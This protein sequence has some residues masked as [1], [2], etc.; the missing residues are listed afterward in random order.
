M[1]EALYSISPKTSLISF[2]QKQATF[3]DC[4]SFQGETSSPLAS[5]PWYSAT[6]WEKRS[7]P[8]PAEYH[9]KEALLAGKETSGS[10][11][12]CHLFPEA[13]R[14]IDSWHTGLI[15]GRPLLV[16]KSWLEGKTFFR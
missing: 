4:M 11:A 10:A 2:F 3:R 15:K 8:P 12:K 14:F 13:K 6:G 1:T 16:A 7:P 5:F 9:K